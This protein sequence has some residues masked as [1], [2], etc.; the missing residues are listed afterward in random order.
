MIEIGK[1]GLVFNPYGGKMSRIPAYVMPFQHRAGNLF[2]VQYSVSWRGSKVRS[3]DELHKR[4]S[5]F[6]FMT[7]CV[8][9]NPRS[10]FL[11]YRDL[12]FGVNRFGNNSY[13]QVKV[14]TAVDPENFF[15]NKKIIPSLPNSRS[16]WD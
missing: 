7:P 14:K 2:K 9:K 13:E 8:S 16:E 5:G 15:Q 3:R 4:K 10:A 1:T 12:E 11:N 6:R